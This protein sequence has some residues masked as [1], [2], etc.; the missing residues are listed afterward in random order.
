MAKQLSRQD[1]FKRFYAEIDA[2]RSILVIGTGNGVSACCAE[3]GGADL[4]AVYNSGFYCINGLPSFVGNLPIGD[5]NDI[6]FRLGRESIM[7]SSRT[8]PVIAGGLR[9]RPYSIDFQRA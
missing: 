3:T 4:A 7:P 5:A 8:I 1:V 9:H 2:K 6:M